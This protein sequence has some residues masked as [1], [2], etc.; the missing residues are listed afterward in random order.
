ML[1]KVLLAGVMVLLLFAGA[2]AEAQTHC[3]PI[4][5]LVAGGTVDNGPAVA[6][7]LAALGPTGGCLEF[8]PGKFLF[9]AAIF[10]SFPAA[11][12]NISIVGSGQGSTILYFCHGYPACTTGGGLI[13]SYNSRYNSV[14]LRD[15]S[16][17]T[18]AANTSGSAIL[19]QQAAWLQDF[20]SNRIANVEIRGDAP[21]NWTTNYWGYGVTINA[22]SNVAFD[23]LLIYGGTNGTNN[24]G[25]GIN[26]QGQSTDPLGCTS[27]G[28]HGACGIVY[29][30]SNSTFFNNNVG[31]LY[32]SYIQGV[33]VSQ[34]N[35]TNGNVGIQSNSSEIG[36]AQLAIV[37]SQFDNA[38]S[39]IVTLT[40]IPQLQI[41]NSLFYVRPGQTGI[42]LASNWQ[43]SI[44]GNQFSSTNANAAI[45]VGSRV[46]TSGTGTI[47]GNTFTNFT[48]GVS[49]LT[50]SGG[51]KV[52]AN[53][54]P[55]TVNPT[56]D[57]GTGN[58]IPAAPWN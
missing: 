3:T 16:I 48:T 43:F 5:G 31:I 9:K 19:L 14:N 57:S 2:N 7:A 36:L 53:T 11:R 12:Q 56:V 45:V 47:T 10:Y 32:G 27:D 44:T 46:L 58:F 34:C 26:L 15:F 42:N 17:T 18:G 54:Y 20:S 23:N 37:N 33:A 4:T 39:S 35:F 50:G 6:S 38:A 8:P 51:V 49:L 52:I 13:F 55:G 41:A 29:N 22:V 21:R 40:H 28:G 30:V 24:Y 1:K 25:V